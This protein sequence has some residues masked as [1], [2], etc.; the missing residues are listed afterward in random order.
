MSFVQKI[1]TKA[2]IEIHS[3]ARFALKILCLNCLILQSW[4]DG[5]LFIRLIFSV[6][7]KSEH[8]TAFES[9]KIWILELLSCT[10]SCV[11]IALCAVFALIIFYLVLWV[12]FALPILHCTLYYMLY[13]ANVIS[14]T[15]TLCHYTCHYTLNVF[16]HSTRCFAVLAT[17]Y[18]R[19]W[20][21]LQ[22]SSAIKYPL[23]NTLANI[24][25]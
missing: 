6:A 21:L 19:T 13:A 23:V 5:D 17:M 1:K 11:C 2:L 16:T 24:C 25:L 4:M 9:H 22:I 7:T 8:S 10:A 14:Y 15:C 18:H 12:V 3:S 20:Y